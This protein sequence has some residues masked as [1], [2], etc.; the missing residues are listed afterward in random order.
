MDPN[1]DPAALEP[2][3]LYRT[4]WVFYLLLAIA[5]VLWFGFDQGEIPLSLFIDPRLWWLD[6][7]LGLG[8]GALLILSWRLGSRF[9]APMRRL[10]E[11]MGEM[12]GGLEKD[13]VLCLALISGFS[14]EL[15][16]RGAMQTAWGWPLATALFGLL[17]VG[18]EKTFRVWTLFALIAGGLFAGLTLWRGNLLPAITAHVLVNGVNLYLLTQA[19]NPPSAEA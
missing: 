12:L 8:S 1:Q 6:L 3:Y 13:Q 2:G 9:F 4:G 17:H 16:F 18:P 15:F 10:E 11:A 14:E 5:G 7:A 19:P